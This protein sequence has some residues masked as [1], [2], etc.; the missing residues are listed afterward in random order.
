MTSFSPHSLT[1]ARELLGEC[2]LLA[3]FR[4]CVQTE[5]GRNGEYPMACNLMVEELD[6]G[7]DLDTI[8]RGSQGRMGYQ[9]Q[10]EAI[11]E[12]TFRIAFGYFAEPTCGDGAEWEVA[13]S[14]AG[15]VLHGSAHD[16]WDC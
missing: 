6:S 11:G 7:L 10:A 14:D 12:N 9:L 16:H 3:F 1:H 8:F 4:W 13:F 15:E 2:R 5:A